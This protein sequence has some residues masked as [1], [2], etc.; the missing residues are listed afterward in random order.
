MKYIKLL[1]H[2]FIETYSNQKSRWLLPFSFLAII[3]EASASLTTWNIFGQRTELNGI[4]A[5]ILAVIVLLIQLPP[6]LF[7]LT[8]VIAEQNKNWLLKITK[9]ILALIIWALIN[10]IG[11]YLLAL[12][13]GSEYPYLRTFG[14]VFY[15][16]SFGFVITIITFIFPNN[17]K[18]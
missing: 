7:F 6:P 3:F 13:I 5:R 8:K 17:K 1:L 15:I 11:V 10:G 2:L 4:F 12:I 18:S 14:T 16:L 9:V